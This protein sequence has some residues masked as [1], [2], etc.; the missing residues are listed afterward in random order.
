MSK[1]RA[2]S[3]AAVLSLGVA[4]HSNAVAPLAAVPIALNVISG[5]TV[6]AVGVS[7]AAASVGA[8]IKGFAVLTAA[9][10][11]LTW[12]L[13]GYDSAPSQVEGDEIN[14]SPNGTN[15]CPNNTTSCTATVWRHY[16][17]TGTPHPSTPNACGTTGW[18]DL[19][20]K[21]IGA[22]SYPDETFT[23][24]STF[25]SGGV[26]YSYTHRYKF[27]FSDSTVYRS[28]A[29]GVEFD[30]LSSG[31]DPSLSDSTIELNP[32]G[33]SF[34]FNSDP[35]IP[36]S[37]GGDT[38]FPVPD[39]S[40]RLVV[41]STNANNQ[42]VV[43]TVSSLPDGGS[44]ISEY[45]QTSPNEV[46]ATQ[47]QVSPTG[48]ISNV[49]TSQAAGTLNPVPI[50]A[51]ASYV[52]VNSP[53]PTNQGQFNPETGEITFPSDYARAGEAAAAAQTISDNLLSGEVITPVV[54]DS[55]M[56]WFGETFD[57]LS[58]FQINTT[59][60][61]CPVWQFDALDE[62]FYIDH[63][64]VLIQDFNPLF[65]AMFTAFWVLLAIRT[66]MEA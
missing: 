66:V 10:T 50:Q 59:G 22:S 5:S 63:H 47:V 62:S 30:G 12:L 37:V 38:G 26:T 23:A 14:E 54:P 57:P 31:Y 7:G 46:S 42:F 17:H 18:Q 34:V 60:A 21:T 52:P 40:G 6:S 28:A 53:S 51:G 44:I 8:F 1:F 19:G 2:L 24:S 32:S 36:A 35:D 41:G 49:S 20:L 4:H 65:Y 61:T 39:D 11:G 15:P 29:T 16:S 33:G 64:C 43:T 13:G 58:G 56:P 48:Q 27:V 9:A 3:V 45:V 55:D 25:C